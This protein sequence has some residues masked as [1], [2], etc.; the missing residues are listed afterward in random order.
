MA[1][2]SWRTLPT[3]PTTSPDPPS[4]EALA[5]NLRQPLRRD[6]IRLPLNFR[7]PPACLF[8]LSHLVEQE[9]TLLSGIAL[10]NLAIIIARSNRFFFRNDYVSTYITGVS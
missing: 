6:N 8:G 5:V 1:A 9:H 3:T 7:S 2:Y 10:A 4:Y